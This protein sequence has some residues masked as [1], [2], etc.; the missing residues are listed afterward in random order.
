MTYH[1]AISTTNE[2]IIST[3]NE[4]NMT[5]FYFPIASKMQSNFTNCYAQ[6]NSSHS[7]VACNALWNTCNQHKF[8]KFEKFVVK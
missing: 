5:N 2:T 7:M 8:V 4:T 3:T 1:F 6:Q